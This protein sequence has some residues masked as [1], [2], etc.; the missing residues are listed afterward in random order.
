MEGM[1]LLDM[2]CGC[3]GPKIGCMLARANACVYGIVPPRE[4]ACCVQ[5][6]LHRERVCVSTTVLMALSWTDPGDGGGGGGG[7]MGVATTPFGFG[8]IGW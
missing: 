7:F 1:Q 3:H 8:L 2:T 5:M 4:G 6:A